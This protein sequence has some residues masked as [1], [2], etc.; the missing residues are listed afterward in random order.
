MS[1]TESLVW[2]KVRHRRSIPGR[3]D[4]ADDL[5]ATWKRSTYFDSHF[6]VEQ[7][8]SGAAIHRYVPASVSYLSGLDGFPNQT[9]CL[10]DDPGQFSC[11]NPAT[12]HGDGMVEDLLQLDGVV[13]STQ[14]TEAFFAVNSYSLPGG[15]VN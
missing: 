12:D 6:N 13:H 1:F 4:G 14:Y 3:G 8:L 9:T 2:S 7:A 15:V 11:A 10:R 5:V